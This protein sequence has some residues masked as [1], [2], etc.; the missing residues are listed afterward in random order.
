MSSSIDNITSIFEDISI[1]QEEPADEEFKLISKSETSL[2]AI[3]DKTI[4][5]LELVDTYEKL[6]NE[7]RL[8]YIN[9]FLNLSRANYNNGSLS[10]KFGPDSFDL[11]PY[12]ACKQIQIKDKFEL[13]DLLKAQKDKSEQAKNKSGQRKDAIEIKETDVKSTMKN[14]KTKKVGREKE[15]D[16]IDE[17]EIQNPKLRDPISQFGCL[18]PYQLKQSQSFFSNGLDIS[19]KIINLQGE[20]KK[21]IEDIEEISK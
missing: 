4:R 12:R 21:L 1:K 15:S 16:E 14:R 10:K 11:R 20:I 3:D 2:S 5:L 7:N 18:V 9:G 6:T 17:I 19:I 8:N 13:V